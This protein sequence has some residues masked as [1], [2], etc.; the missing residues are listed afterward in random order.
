MSKDVEVGE[1]FEVPGYVTLKCNKCKKV[2]E[3]YIT[4]T[5]QIISCECGNTSVIVDFI[6]LD[7]VKIQSVIN[8][9]VRKFNK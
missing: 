9:E 8:D 7:Y 2:F 5:D 6:D 1:T 4:S 3:K